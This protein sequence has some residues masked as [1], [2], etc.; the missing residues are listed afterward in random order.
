MK[1]LLKILS[2]QKRCPMLFLVRRKI[3]LLSLNTCGGYI[4]ASIS[5]LPATASGRENAVHTPQQRLRFPQQHQE[6]E[7]DIHAA[8]ASPLTATACSKVVQPTTPTGH[9]IGAQ[10]V[11]S[12]SQSQNRLVPC[13]VVQILCTCKREQVNQP[14]GANSRGFGSSLLC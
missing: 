3:C 11:L 8:A 1:E 7:R 6:G 4:H 14:R 13:P 9:G 2:L 5:P 12:A 10:P